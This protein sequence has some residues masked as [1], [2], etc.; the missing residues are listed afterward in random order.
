MSRLPILFEAVLNMYLYPLFLLSTLPSTL[1]I[2]IISFCSQAML[3]KHVWQARYCVL[4]TTRL[5]PSHTHHTSPLP[6]ALNISLP[7]A[8]L[9]QERAGRVRRE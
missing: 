6:I 4:E 5:V 1:Y 8:A 2:S 3:G 7:H 9:L